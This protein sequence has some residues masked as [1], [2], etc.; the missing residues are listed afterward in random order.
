MMVSLQA[1]IPRIV[2][3]YRRPGRCTCLLRRQ[4]SGSNTLAHSSISNSPWRHVRVGMQQAQGIRSLELSMEE[5]IPFVE[6][7]G[8][9]RTIFCYFRASSRECKYTMVLE[10]GALPSN[11]HN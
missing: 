5:T 1:E 9:P 10:K 8:L 11:Q 6:E 3:L 7:N 4:P 2:I